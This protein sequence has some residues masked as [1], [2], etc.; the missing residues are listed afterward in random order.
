MV[1]VKNG[2]QEKLGQLFERYKK[3]LYGF[4][5]GLTRQQDV[6]EDLIQN[7]FF[8]ILKYRHLFREQVDSNGGEFRAWLF[9]IARNVHYDQHRKKKLPSD[10]L[11]NWKD[12]VGHTENKASEM[13]QSEELQLL[14]VAMDKLPLEKRE[15]ILLSKYEDL[16][17][18]EIGEVLGCSEGAVK[19]KVFRAL[20]ELKVIYKQLERIN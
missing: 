8:R 16:K 19:V 6:S 17:Y 13:Q 3:P 5:Y 2:D 1:K 9:H 18:S 20:Q 14:A 11:E 7:T 4:F 10:D 15:I 12:R